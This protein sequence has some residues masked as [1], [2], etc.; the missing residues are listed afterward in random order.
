MKKQI[1]WQRWPLA[2]Q[3]GIISLLSLSLF[4]LLVAAN[5]QFLVKLIPFVDRDF[6]TLWAGGKALLVGIDP[7]EPGQWEP[8][9]TSFGSVWIPNPWSPYPLWTSMFFVFL[10]WLPVN[11]AAAIWLSIT[12]LAVGSSIFLLATQI[13]PRHLTPVSYLAILV[14]GFLFRGTSLT[15]LHGQLTALLLLVVTMFL[16]LMKNR[17]HILAGICLALI[18]LKPTSFI[19]FAP[20]IV[21]WLIRRGF[22]KVIYGGATATALI[23]VTSW[24][25]QP[26]WPLE[27]LNA[28]GKVYVTY[29][30]PTVWG[31]AY[32][33]SPIWWPWLGTGFAIIVTI[34]LGWYCLNCDRLGIEDVASLALAASLVITP[35]AWAYEHAL[36]VL[37]L[38]LLYGRIRATAQFTLIWSFL[39]LALPWI[40]FGIALE[41]KVD[42]FSVF[43]PISTGCAYLLSMVR[44]NKFRTY[45]LFDN[46]GISI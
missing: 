9:F 6:M 21:I 11:Y 31:L 33:I 23:V 45:R 4:G 39:A 5:F 16:F 30:T 8:L 38:T 24:L 25:V 41:R 2:M 42:T 46:K 27:W 14:G 1:D 35:Y 20:L 36:L 22:W 12:E 40:L 32:E 26:G 17:Q 10:A 44:S 7:Y 3:M 43:I 19:L 18:V 29:Q 28:R 34:I 37:P 13:G 15:I